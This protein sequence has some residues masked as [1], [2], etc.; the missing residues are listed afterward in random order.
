MQERR[1]PV[2]CFCATRVATGKESTCRPLVPMTAEGI[3]LTPNPFACLEADC[4][5][6]EDRGPNAPT[7]LKGLQR[8]HSGSWRDSSSWC[9]CLVTMS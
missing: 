8:S 6:E 5:M 9:P 7:Y 3:R 2:F 4:A 1:L